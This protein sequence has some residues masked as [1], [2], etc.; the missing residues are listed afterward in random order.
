[1]SKDTLQR[2]ALS[3]MLFALSASICVLVLFAGAVIDLILN[4]FRLW[5]RNYVLDIAVYLA[6]AHDSWLTFAQNWLDTHIAAGEASW[7]AATGVFYG[8]A[9][10]SAIALIYAL[11][12]LWE[13]NVKVAR[14][15]LGLI[16]FAAF[17][18][19]SLVVYQVDPRTG[20]I[21]LYSFVF[22]M[23]NAGVGF[24]GMMFIADLGFSREQKV[25]RYAQP[26]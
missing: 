21:A 18:T 7:L 3:I 23:L 5:N 2:L 13:R 6:L 24:I 10:P 17:M 20:N 12:T 26:E 15:V 22:L 14:V 9:I 16:F 25:S 11:L 8:T 19:P 4:Y 1:M